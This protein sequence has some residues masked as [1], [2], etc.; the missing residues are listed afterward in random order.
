[1]IELK[2][3]TCVYFFRCNGAGHSIK[4]H[5]AITVTPRAFLISRIA[6]SLNA[7][8][9]PFFFFFSLFFNCCLRSHHRGLFCTNDFN[10]PGAH[11]LAVKTG[12]VIRNG[13]TSCHG[14]YPL[15]IIT[16]HFGARSLEAARTEQ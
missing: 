14:K 10:I 3:D 5:S 13:Y 6:H 4:N 16:L 11:A 15:E 12:S 8:L 9:A 1:M 7:A 2:I